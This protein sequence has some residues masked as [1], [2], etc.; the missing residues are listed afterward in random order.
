MR[1]FSLLPL[2]GIAAATLY[3]RRFW[4]SGGAKLSS[5]EEDRVGERSTWRFLGPDTE[6]E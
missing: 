6:R 1:I 2:C 4:G 5:D 3:D